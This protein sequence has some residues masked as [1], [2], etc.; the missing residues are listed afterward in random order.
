MSKPLDKVNVLSR[1]EYAAAMNAARAMAAVSG[2]SIGDVERKM[3]DCLNAFGLSL[4]KE[5]DDANKK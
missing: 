1:D 4:N 5:E 2:I 3:S